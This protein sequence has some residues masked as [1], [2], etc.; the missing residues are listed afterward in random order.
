MSRPSRWSAQ[1]CSSLAR[2]RRAEQSLI[3]V[4]VQWIRD[5]AQTFEPENNTVR[6]QSGDALTYEYLVVCTGVKLDWNNIA[7]LAETLGKNGI[8][9]ELFAHACHLLL[10]LPARAEG[11][12][13]RGIH[14]AAAAVQMPR[15]DAED[16]LSRRHHLQRHGI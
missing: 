15:R 7:G 8:L 10:G 16:R 2:T 9:I 11:R 14:P 4:G 1:A 5:A 13:P 12:Q 6:S 3:P